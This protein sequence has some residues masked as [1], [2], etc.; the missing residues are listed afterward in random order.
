MTVSMRV[1]S[2]GDG[3]RYLLKTVAVGDGNRD[4][5]TPLT[6]Y[7]AEAGTPPG[8]WIGSGVAALG[9]GQLTPGDTV[10]EEQLALLLGMGRDPITG[11]PLGRVFPMY[12][13]REERIRARIGALDPGLSVDD[14]AAAVTAIE[15][16]ETGRGG[17]RAV[18]GF[19]YTFSVPKSVS[20]WWAVADAG[21]Q[22]L[23]ATAHHGA[24]AEVIDLMER[25][26]AATRTGF[27]ATD[28]AVAQV[29]VTGLIATSFD[30]YD[31]RAGDP[32]LH[33]HVVISNKVRTVYDGKWRSLDGRPMHA[34]VVALSEHYNGLLADHLTRALGVGWEQRGRGRDR[35]PAWELTSV[36]EELIAEFSSRSRDI[37]AEKDRLIA[38]YVAAHGREP[39]ATTVIKLRAQATL[40]TRPEK[41]VRSLA[42][43][44]ADWRSRATGVLG[45]DAPTW[46]MQLI[47]T[48]DRPRTLRADDIPLDLLG[49]VGRTVVG[50]VGDRRS[51]WR[52]WNL[53]AEASRQVMGLRFASAED[54]EAVIGLIVDAAEQDSLRLTPPE[55]A[56][57]PVVFQRPDGTSVFRPKHS[58]IFSST[59]LLA[60]EDRL[61]ELSHSTTAPTVDI[62]AVEEITHRPDA[63]GRVLGED[64]AA[65]LAAVA[66]SGRVVDVLVGP[67]GAGKTTAMNVLRR[68]W[69]HEHGTGS[70]VG[71]APSAVAAQVLADDLGIGTENTAKWLH[72]HTRGYAEFRAGQLVIVDEAS[73]A[74]TRTLDRIAAHAA[75]SGAKVLLVGDWAQLDA[76]EAGGTFGMLVR[77]RDDV[78]E[79]ADVHRFRHDWEKR[80]SLELRIG[81]TDVIDIYQHRGRIRDGDTEAMLDAAY[82]AWLADLTAGHQSVIIAETQDTVTALNVRARLDRIIAGQVAPTRQVGLH[83]STEASKGDLVITRRNDRRLL[84][85]KGWVKNGD[86]WIV[87]AT[88]GDG[89]VTVRRAGR[90]IGASVVLPAW[91][92][93][94]HLELAYAV[95]THRA[96]GSTVETAHAVVHSPAMTR[97]GFYVAMTRGREANTAYVATDQ[98]ELEGHQ[99]LPGDEVTARSVLLGVLRHAGAELSA[100]ETIEAEHDRWSGIAQLAAEYETIAAAAQQDRWIALVERCGLTPEQVD[101]VLGSDAY[102]PLTAE[103]RRA[104]ANHY[105]V[106]TLLPRLVAARGFADAED[107]AAV[108][109][110]RVATA[111]THRTGT[112]RG[113][114]E[115]RLIAGLIP[116]ATGP[117]TD[118]LRHALD[119]RKQL[120]EDRADALTQTALAQDESWTRHLGA[121]PRDPQRR[122]AWMRH[123]RIVAAYRDRHHIMA[124][125]PLGPAAE[126]TTQRINAARA[127]AALLQAQQVTTADAGSEVRSMPPRHAGTSL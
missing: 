2:A 67:A 88:N 11:D 40:T 16:E 98:A 86:R 116:E 95:T 74:G 19:D 24:V 48:A 105:D 59:E 126:S 127:R 124:S 125:S 41:E 25:E 76:V 106:D 17:R 43:L 55:L 50:V 79:L 70:V 117:M 38:E 6:C 1:V 37:D 33:T 82:A 65:A 92:V 110:Y 62:A 119:E 15:S 118:E 100:H 42:E 66:V 44:T 10:S 35:N 7:Y 104:E 77:A 56:P 34:A 60:A 51:T 23:I 108:L 3:Y 109:H 75:E 30:H 93:A 81:D 89:S 18:A 9:A 4:L 12:R 111:A 80:A 21:A 103:L 20:A 28:G 29:D 49:E 121:P 84:A 71:L 57:S 14:R 8:T 61:L 63:Q 115:A 90:R 120:I 78:P 32:Q 72:D 22:S 68:A 83:D 122:R 47:A 53:H 112:S 123:A 46:A 31:S 64:Q 58:V 13:P 96:Q 87:T 52:R 39:S 97:E 5:T 73:L 94:E 114:P 85:G 99:H 101:A 45:Q 36:P 102:G 27:A 69:E 91:Y 107:V 26:V 113:R 54:R